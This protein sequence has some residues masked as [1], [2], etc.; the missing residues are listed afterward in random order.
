[1]KN[2]DLY[3]TVCSPI[4]LMGVGVRVGLLKH[5][6]LQTVYNVQSSCCEY[7]PNKFQN[8]S[9]MHSCKYTVLMVLK[10]IEKCLLVS[11]LVL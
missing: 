1:M 2:P 3:S 11:F 7:S 8:G 9:G 4:L 6:V 10:C 5:F